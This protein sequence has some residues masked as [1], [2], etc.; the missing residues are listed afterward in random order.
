MTR[1]RLRQAA[2]KEEK[3]ILGH[4]LRA[5]RELESAMNKCAMLSRALRRTQEERL[6]PGKKKGAGKIKAKTLEEKREQQREREKRRAAERQI[7]RRRGE[8]KRV[9]EMQNQLGG[10]RKMLDRLPLLGL[11]ASAPPPKLKP[12][13]QSKPGSGRE[14]S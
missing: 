11:Q 10:S 9:Q 5:Q 1:I 12:S 8:W 14:K 6:D 2:V 13:P 7:E 4:V 3:E